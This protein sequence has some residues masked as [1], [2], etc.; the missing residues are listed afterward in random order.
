M[1]LF[2]RPGLD[3]IRSF[4]SS[5]KDL[6]FSYA[7]V[8]SSRE[9]APSGYNADHNRARLGTGV[10]DFDRAITAIRQWKMFDL[11]WIQ[12]CWPDAPIEPG[13]TVAVAVSHLG[14]WSL[15]A[16]RIVYVTE[17]HG[18]IEKYGF[19]YGTL[20][21]HAARGEER[22]TVEFDKSDGAV[23]YDI[24]AFSRPRALARLA[25]PLTRSLQ[26][27]FAKD[28]KAGMLRGIRKSI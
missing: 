13:A 4:I 15:N 10:D 6:P 20:P 27:R 5:Q 25:Y 28:S 12:L 22:F 21:G 7:E 23:W 17:E 11:P 2:S 8:G 18:K 26:M 1:F 9:N 14:F 16:C 19:A 24:L 3:A